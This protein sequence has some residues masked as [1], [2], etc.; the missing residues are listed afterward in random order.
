M[1][2][3]KS[4]KSNNKSSKNITIKKSA[5]LKWLSYL[6]LFVAFLQ[7]VAASLQIVYFYRG[8]Y[9]I[10][11]N[12]WLVV[13]NE[14]V[15]FILISIFEMLMGSFGK[16][17]ADGDRYS[18][19]V[20]RKFSILAISLTLLYVFIA[21]YT[22]SEE[23]FRLLAQFFSPMAFYFVTFIPNLESQMEKDAKKANEKKAVENK[24]KK[25]KSEAKK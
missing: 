25:T 19:K 3:K 21:L 11:T 18:L 9:T 4:T 2:K 24:D 5:I 6:M 8:L 10:K 16:K 17:G 20:C 23:G 22:K 1:E 13:L 12:Y 7:L 14:T 15:I